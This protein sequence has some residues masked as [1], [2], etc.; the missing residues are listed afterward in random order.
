MR[1][2][3]E[4]VVLRWIRFST[5][6]AALIRAAL[7]FVIAVPLCLAL[8]TTLGEGAAS[9]SPT[10]VIERGDIAEG[11]IPFTYPL[12]FDVPQAGEVGPITFYTD[13]TS[14]APEEKILSVPDP[15]TGWD[16]S[17]TDIAKQVVSCVYTP[18]SPLAVGSSVSLN[19][20]AVMSYLSSPL[21]PPADMTVYQDISY[22]VATSQ[23][24]TESDELENLFVFPDNVAL[25]MNLGDSLSGSTGVTGTNFDY[26]ANVTI[27]ETQPG[28]PSETQPVSV[29]DILPAGTALAS[30]GPSGTGWDCSAS[31]IATSKV[32]CTYQP[33]AGGS[34]QGTALPTITIPAQLTDSTVGHALTNTADASSS[35]TAGT[36]A[37]DI[38]TVASPNDTTP[39]TVTNVAAAP[40]LVALGSGTTLSATVADV[41][42][43]GTNVV[44]AQYKINGASWV[45]MSGSFGA[46]SVNVTAAIP[47][48][49]SPVADTLCVRGED[50]AGNWSD[51]TACTSFVVY[52]PSAGFVTGGGWITSP[53]GACAQLSLCSAAAGKGTFGF[54]SKYQKGA[55]VPSGNT[56]YVLH[57]GNLNFASSS[58]QWLV[59]NQNGTNAQFK[60]T[61]TINGAG[62]YQ[63][64][65][66]ATQGSPGTFRIQVTDPGTGNTIYDSGTQV[67]GGGSVV[68]H[69]S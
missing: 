17:K 57:D 30:A 39:P 35:D 48:P 15:G 38:V 46:P 52:D 65:I 60:G 29:T 19:V 64:M 18:G 7:G 32:S 13:S 20:E 6:R 16:C 49:A 5:R 53:P 40:S 24:G 33:P 56:Q 2:E 11:G 9:A 62:T 51:G 41:E 36:S 34:P 1:P 45:A 37:S 26:S 10:S 14:I 23:D 58:Y 25:D 47:A 43:G 63:F 42:A 27:D 8:A 69:K 22:S 67:L 3:E 44:A 54:V 61:G 68:V 28:S 50:A 66:W 4:A 21:N 31:V 12:T 55:T 59:V